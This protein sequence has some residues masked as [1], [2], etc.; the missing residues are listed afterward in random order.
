MLVIHW[1]IYL[2]TIAI[3]AA[4]IAID[5]AVSVRRPHVPSMREAALWIGVYVGLALIFALGLGVVSGWRWSG[6]FL[7]GWLTEYSLSVDNVFVFALILASFAVPAVHQQKALLWGIVAALIL[8]GAFIAAGAAAI[9][10]FT[11]TFYVFGAILFFT[12]VQLLRG[13]EHEPDPR[14]NPIWRLVARLVPTTHE[15]V[16]GRV[17]TR[18]DGRRVATPLLLV[19]VAIGSTDVLFALDSIPAI[20]GLTREPYLVLTANAFAL[21]GLRQLYFL[22]LGLLERLRYLRYGLAIILGFIGVKLVLEAAHHNFENLPEIPL[23]L[24]LAVIIGVLAV[25]AIV[26]LTPSAAP[27]SVERPARPEP[28]TRAAGVRR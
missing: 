17:F 12:A 18:I 5:V 21:M 11:A 16:G 20:Y 6:E 15:Y 26:S 4:L 8:R 2:V 22:L 9:Q 27:N 3:L 7:A 23:W 24:S 14:R 10:R 19:F 25:T 28:P 13:G 1:W